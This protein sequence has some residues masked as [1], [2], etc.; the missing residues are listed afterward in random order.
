MIRIALF[1]NIKNAFTL[2]IVK[3]LLGKK[4][5]DCSFLIYKPIYDS[6]FPDINNPNQDTFTSANDLLNRADYLF[7]IGGDG[8]LLKTIN[9]VRDSGI[10]VLGINTGRLGFLSNITNDEIDHALAVIQKKDY[11]LD[12]RILLEVESEQLEKGLYHFALNDFTLQKHESS[13]MIAVHVSIND[14]FLNTYWADGLLVS[15]ATGS[16][17]YSL[18]CGGPILLPESEMFVVSPIAPHNLNV[19]PIVV[20]ADCVLK[21]TVESRDRNFVATLDS[22]AVL[23]SAATNFTLKKAKHKLNLLRFDNHDFLNTLRN[24]LMWGLDKRNY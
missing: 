11:K 12:Q 18:S 20:P 13:S 23:M 3:N 6:I 7:S 14:K 5:A 16:T 24:K 2:E 15:T 1:G 22:N 17:A 19:R 8:T 9:L 4:L 21:L 10:P